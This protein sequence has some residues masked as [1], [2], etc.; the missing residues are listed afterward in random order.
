V[1]YKVTWDGDG[2]N[3]EL[4]IM[5]GKDVVAKV[6]ARVVELK[7]SPSDNA[8]V[9]NT[10][11]DGSRSISEI[12]FAGKKYAMAIAGESAQNQGGSR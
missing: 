3:V 2:P 10:N 12:R 7:S 11:G 5:K 1:N 6:P 8:V 4:N 9:V